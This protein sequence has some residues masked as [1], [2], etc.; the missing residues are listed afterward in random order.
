MIRPP[1]SHCHRKI[2]ESTRF[3]PYFK[4]CVGAID[5][6]HVLTRVP[7]N[8]SV[9]FRGIKEG[10]TQNVMAAVDFDLK[11]TY[12]LAGWEGSAHDVLIL[13]NALERGERLKVPAGI[14]LEHATTL[15][16]AGS[17]N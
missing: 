8:I 17:S 1:S 9:A 12:V 15:L 2:Q 5:G 10:T 4:D 3:N 16:I 11:F 7:K 14:K 6:T 13:A